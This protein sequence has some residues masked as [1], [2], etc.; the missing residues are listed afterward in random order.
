MSS[1]FSSLTQGMLSVNEAALEQ[2]L[3]WLAGS[4]QGRDL[5]LLV[6][7]LPY[8]VPAFIISFLLGSKINVLTMGE[9]VAK[10]LGQKTWLIKALMAVSIIL[11]AGGSVAVAGRS[12]LSVLLSRILQNLSSATTIAGFFRT[13][14]CWEPSCL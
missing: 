11:L 5:S 13:V 1:L 14:P 10:S 8:I 2:A 6:S 4:V 3:F 9:E 7:V 12:V